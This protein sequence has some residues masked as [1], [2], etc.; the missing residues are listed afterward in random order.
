MHIAGQDRIRLDADRL[1]LRTWIGDVEY[2]GRDGAAFHYY[3]PV[4]NAVSL[5]S[6]AQVLAI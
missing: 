1:R 2:S 3:F 6:S 4:S 5:G